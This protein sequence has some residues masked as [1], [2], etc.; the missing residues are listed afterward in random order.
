MTGFQLALPGGFAL[1]IDGD[2]ATGVLAN[3]TSLSI[4]VAGQ[5]SVVYVQSSPKSLLNAR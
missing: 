4:R 3:N 1:Q 2:D 5:I